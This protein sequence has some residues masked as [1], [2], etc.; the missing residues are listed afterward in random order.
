MK[1]NKGN[2]E[3]GRK[4]ATKS[5]GEIASDR[6]FKKRRK[7]RGKKTLCEYLIRKPN[8]DSNFNRIGQR[9]VDHSPT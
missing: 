4:I 8:P 1:D 2:R 7:D 6:G 3:R 9:K 5:N